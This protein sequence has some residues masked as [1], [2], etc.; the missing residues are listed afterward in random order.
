ML[1][2]QKVEKKLF[3]TWIDKYNIAA[4]III[5]DSKFDSSFIFIKPTI[6]SLISSESAKLLVDGNATLTHHYSTNCP[7]ITGF[8][9]YLTFSFTAAYVVV[10]YYWVKSLETSSF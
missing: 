7:E 6:I 9:A 1:P 8:Y 4:L 10:V 5:S 3:E 2:H